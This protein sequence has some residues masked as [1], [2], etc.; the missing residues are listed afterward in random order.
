MPFT[1]AHPALVI[2]LLH[3]RRRY[4]WVSA[5]GLIA[6]SIAPDF[7]K[8][9]TLRLANDYSHTVL[10]IFY[11]SV[12]VALVLALVFHR[13]VRRPLLAHLPAPLHGRLH[14]FAD[15]DWTA[16]LRKHPAGVLAS[17]V[18]SAALHLLWDRFTHLNALTTNPN[19]RLLMHP[20][21]IQGRSVPLFQLFAWS[22]SVVGL[23]AIVWAIWQMPRD[24]RAVGPRPGSRH[25]FWAVAALVALGLGT[26][27]VLLFPVRLA[28]AGIVVISAGMTGIAIAAVWARR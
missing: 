25:R 6:G 15:F 19:M 4:G 1:F 8:F 16:H 11:F 18:L 22:S 21:R 5:T 26:S 20:V 10:S 14:R 13:V 23:I 7:E 2:P 9:L 28:D 3:P 24:M 17:I 27:W 12:P